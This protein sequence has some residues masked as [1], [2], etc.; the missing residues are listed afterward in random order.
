MKNKNLFLVFGQLSLAVSF[1]LSQFVIETDFVS[2]MIGFFIG[3]SI[4]FNLAFLIS[5]RKKKEN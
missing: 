5:L 3:L 4:V 2:C 1:L